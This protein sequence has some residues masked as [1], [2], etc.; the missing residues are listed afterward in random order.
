[1][2]RAIVIRNPGG[3]DALK[4]EE[5]RLIEPGP[6]ELLIRQTVI[7]LNYM[8]VH[9]RRGDSPIKA[10]LAVPG[11]ES[12]G[13]VEAIG[14]KVDGYTVGERVACATIPYGAYAEH[15]IIDVDR[16]IAVPDDISDEMVAAVLAKGLTVHYLVFRAF[17][18]KQ[19]QVVLIHAA[20]GGV[21][22][23]LCQWAK[24]RGATVIATVGS[25]EKVKMAKSTG[26]DFVIDLGTENLVERVK[27]ITNGALVT[28][29]YDGVGKDTFMDSLKCLT[30]LGLMVSY[31]QSSGV[32]PPVDLDL[33]L[34]HSLFLTRP[35][36]FLY[37]S[38]KMELILSENEVFSQIRTGAI[39][40]KLNKRYPFT[41]E[42]V[43]EAH[44]DLEGRK[45]MGASIITI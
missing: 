7:G 21:G 6:N 24:Q 41:E 20:A 1:M 23:V 2:S 44:K 5:V 34:E 22:H 11:F 4:M 17:A 10:G 13:V 8:D 19:G 30:P 40:M 43:R 15:R 9:Q 38:N 26:A 35:S 28:V 3:L 12:V 27:A 18:I 16:A 45:T 31:G 14:N 42:G 25:A 33:L 37:K 29:V 39:K 32:V 36:L